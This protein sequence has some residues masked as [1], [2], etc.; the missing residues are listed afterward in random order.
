[1]TAINTGVDCDGL[2]TST[3]TINPSSNRIGLARTTRQRRDDLLEAAGPQRSSQRCHRSRQPRGVQRLATC[4]ALPASDRASTSHYFPRRRG[5]RTLGQRARVD[6]HRANRRPHVPLV[7]L[8][9]PHLM[10]ARR[11]PGSQPILEVKLD[12][13][14]CMARLVDSPMARR[15][16]AGPV[17]RQPKLHLLVALDVLPDLLDDLTPAP[18]PADEERVGPERLPTTTLSTPPADVQ[19][20]CRQL[21]PSTQASQAG[22][23]G[24]KNGARNWS[25]RDNNL[26][27]VVLG[28]SLHVTFNMA[29]DTVVLSLSLHITNNMAID[30]VINTNTFTRLGPARTKPGR[31]GHEGRHRRPEE[32]EP[33]SVFTL[34]AQ[35]ATARY[36]SRDAAVKQSS[37]GK[38]N[39]MGK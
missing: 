5:A 8:A 1:M 23:P 14:V 9:R 7:G 31:R 16:L 15:M 25:R 39:R 28:L 34:D 36:M 29:I 33:E 18:V 13:G 22:A 37:A 2:E 30:T 20:R 3:G 26:L 4:A 10:W 12:E 21:A 24:N 32:A 19:P 38:A 6:R 11:R 27:N 17:I 35:V